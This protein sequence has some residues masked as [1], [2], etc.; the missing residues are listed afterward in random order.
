MKGRESRPLINFENRVSPDNRAAVCEV[1]EHQLNVS[2]NYND[3]KVIKDRFEIKTITVQGIKIEGFAIKEG[4]YKEFLKVYGEDK[5]SVVVDE[6]GHVYYKETNSE[7]YIY[8]S[9][10]DSMTKYKKIFEILKD[11]KE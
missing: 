9:T 1:L 3:D 2:L 10:I 7:E 5:A 4:E 8:D 6:E 11:N